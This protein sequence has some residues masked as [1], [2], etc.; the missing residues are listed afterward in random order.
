[1][2]G[3]IIDAILVLRRHLMMRIEDKNK[4]IDL[5]DSMPYPEAK[6]WLQKEFDRNGIHKEAYK[7]SSG[8]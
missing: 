6:E 4:M 7:K 2:S 3:K 5:V 8:T 1:M